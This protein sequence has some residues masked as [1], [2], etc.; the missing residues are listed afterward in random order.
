MAAAGKM[1]ADL[2]VGGLARHLEWLGAEVDSLR[3]AL[4]EAEDRLA[5]Q[6]AQHA[7]RHDAA[8]VANRALHVK[9]RAAVDSGGMSPTALELPQ[10]TEEWSGLEQLGDAVLSLAATTASARRVSTRVRLS[11]MHRE[12]QSLESRTT[13]S[14]FRRYW[15]RWMLFAAPRAA[16]AARRR[17]VAEAQRRIAAAAAHRL[18]TLR[19]SVWVR[20]HRRWRQL[21]DVTL[22]TRREHHAR[23]WRRL[24][25]Y[26]YFSRRRRLR[27]RRTA[28]LVATGLQRRRREAFARLRLHA[29]A[30]L[31]RAVG[32]RRQQLERLASLQR[33]VEAFH[34]EMQQLAQTS[35]AQLA[36][37][38]RDADAASEERCQKLRFQLQE[39]H[40]EHQRL[41][42]QHRSV[43]DEM[44]RVAGGQ[45]DALRD[46]MAEFER[47]CG[48]VRQ[49]QEESVA[50]Q[51]TFVTTV[52]AEQQ[53]AVAQLRQQLADDQRDALARSA[54]STAQGEAERHSICAAALQEQRAALDGALAEQQEGFRKTVEA[55]TEAHRLSREWLERQEEFCEKLKRDQRDALDAHGRQTEDRSRDQLRALEQRLADL[56]ASDRDGAIAEV[57]VACT[58]L[59][60][61]CTHLAQ[62]VE[63]SLKSLSNTNTVLN[64]VVDRLIGVDAHI[65]ALEKGRQLRR[66]EAVTPTAISPADPSPALG[67]LPG[68]AHRIGSV[69][70][71]P[72]RRQ[73]RPPSPP[74]LAALQPPPPPPPLPSRVSGDASPGARWL[75][76]RPRLD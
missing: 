38:L 69:H 12:L 76:P 10:M 42:D 74:E 18:R 9:L 36:D 73:P 48:R 33:T 2:A 4:R 15:R 41:R 17:A 72:R 23:Y 70:V 44:V 8:L 46:A 47:E 16:T 45:R 34:R 58:G 64:K 20:W 27:E 29:E 53:R 51:H 11:Q 35:K 49:W 3:T 40:R 25:R 66:D 63:V 52:T 56:I 1:S 75:A 39:L 31:V 57:G 14:V 19:L 32:T 43:A 21:R 50:E 13:H 60:K 54:Q 67:L 62:Q 37:G 5:A 65:D 26:P 28:A 7:A 61:K 68:A 30:R 59:D 55:A 24:A 71:S 22:A 6:E